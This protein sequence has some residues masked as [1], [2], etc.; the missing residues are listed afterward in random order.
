VRIA[1]RGPAEA[2][3]PGPIQFESLC[4]HRSG[5]ADSNRQTERLSS[6][7][8]LA[9]ATKRCRRVP[10][11]WCSGYLSVLLLRV[12]SANVLLLPSS[13]AFS[14]DAAGPDFHRGERCALPRHTEQSS[15]EFASANAAAGAQDAAVQE[16]WFSPEI[17]INACRRLQ[18]LQRPTPS[19]LSPNAPRASRCGDGHVAD[20]RRSSS[21]KIPEPPTLRARPMAM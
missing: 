20:R 8:L 7:S 11:G 13:L 3:T 2:R 18:H 9:C 17:P 1:R 21:L 16:P 12:S 4:S 15:G 6:T 10:T 19:H 14:L 5:L